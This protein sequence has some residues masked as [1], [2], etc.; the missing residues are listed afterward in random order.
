MYVYRHKSHCKYFLV[1]CSTTHYTAQP[2]NALNG[3]P[4][5][6]IIGLQCHIH[7]DNGFGNV[8]WYWSHCDQDAG[9]NGTAI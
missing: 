5:G 4:L 6:G 7:Q 8:T 1:A 9:V 3:D 2:L